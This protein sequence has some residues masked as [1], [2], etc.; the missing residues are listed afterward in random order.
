ML[1]IQC[2]SNNDA[3]RSWISTVAY[4][5]GISGFACMPRC[6]SANIFA[7]GQSDRLANVDAKLR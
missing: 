4:E 1:L 3:N 7:D 2:C 5:A 6:C